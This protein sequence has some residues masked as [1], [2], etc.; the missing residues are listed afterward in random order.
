[1]SAYGFNARVGPVF[2]DA[3]ITGPAGNAVLK[4]MLDTGATTSLINPSAL[5]SLGFDPD[6]SARRNPMTTGSTIELVP[7]V[8]L[9]R[10]TALGQHRFGFPVIAYALPTSPTLDGLLGL[11]F[12]RGQVLALDFRAGQITLV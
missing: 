2:V 9:T 5:V 8:V 4:L 11:D 10:L 12:M 1:M 7:I 6:T 3:E